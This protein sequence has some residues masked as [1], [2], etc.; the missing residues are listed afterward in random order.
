MES[1]PPL[2][3]MPPRRWLSFAGAVLA[4][5]LWL[6]ATGYHLR[7]ILGAG[8]L[9][10]VQALGGAVLV[11]FFRG[12]IR[13]FLPRGK[14][15]EEATADDPFA[16]V[17]GMLPVGVLLC[18][19]R[20][21]MVRCNS[22]ALEM[23]GR[24][25]PALE[26]LDWL[27]PD[28]PFLKVDGTP[29]AAE[30]LP[31]PRILRG[32]IRIDGDVLGVERPGG[33]DWIWLSVKGE[34]LADRRGRVQ[35]VLVVLED[36]TGRT[37][38]QAELTLQT[39][40]DRLTSLPNRTLFL[41]RVQQ[42]LLRLERRRQFVAI[43]R[44]DL[45]RFKLVN[46][47][48][49]HEAGDRLLVQMAGRIRSCVRPEDTVARLGGDDFAVLFEDLADA[50]HAMVVADRIQA[51]C[52]E[53]LE[54]DG[55]EVF[56]GCSMGLALTNRAGIRAQELLHDAE[57]AMYRAKTK[58]QG[59]VEIF[60]PSMNQAAKDRLRL[61]G[62]LR[63]A[64]EQGE[65][66]LHYQPLV[67]FRTGRIEGWE[68]LVRWQH[69]DRGMVSPL[70][71]IPMAEETGLIVPIGNWV[72]EEACRQASEW[73]RR[74]PTDPPRMI[75]VNLS[76]RQFQQKE[77]VEMV[78]TAL[79]N[80]RLRPRHLKLEITE[81]V[82][83]KDPDTSIEAMR[84]FKGLNIA[85][86]IDDFGTGYSSLSYLK[87]F[88]VDALKVDKSFV[89]RLGRGPEDT[90]IV[91]AIVSMAKALGMRVTG[92]GI[93][94][95][96]QF[97]RLLALGCDQGQGYLFSKPLGSEAMEELLARDPCWLGESVNLGPGLRP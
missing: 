64:L 67:S 45:D 16:V 60:D 5:G 56:T 71:F 12:A 38:T 11:L 74:F 85:L 70:E 92:E 94:T 18:D 28:P 96:A 17:F 47:S 39:F 90:A 89:D 52:G 51:A 58:G 63:H 3:A 49:G 36:I 78:T 50:S 57:L 26:R 59:A 46:D 79:S 37:Q 72:L 20:G 81:S 34:P 13:R 35:E 41:E 42:S 73:Q 6:W 93:E 24:E 91:S 83:M 65:F 23:L 25:L 82:M 95:R 1:S 30:E 53:R 43:L 29:W 76:M 44:L 9:L 88:P 22:R 77:L 66:K 7:G 32:G 2:P 33:E 97:E 8:A 21:R 19:R 48:L 69:P 31:V 75:N 68:A 84:I 87:R 14:V 80:Q 10:L 86:V 15:E 55:Q 27:N 54:L 40:Q 61:E 4:M 62:E